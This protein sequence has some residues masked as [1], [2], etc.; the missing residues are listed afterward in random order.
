M[1]QISWFNSNMFEKIT[2]WCINEE[3]Y[4][5]F[6]CSALSLFFSLIYKVLV[7]HICEFLC[8]V[9]IKS[10]GIPRKKKKSVFMCVKR[11][12]WDGK[13]SPKD[14]LWL[15]SG[16]YKVLT[17]QG[18]QTLAEAIILF[19]VTLKSV[20]FDLEMLKLSI[21][22]I[23]LHWAKSDITSACLGVS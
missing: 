8:T 1:G 13:K 16:Q 4:W 9:G 19:S 15:A 2:K 11:M 22:T 7:Q 12:R 20:N 3:R 23:N 10:L 5:R 6:I 21:P 18:A 17:L 14:K